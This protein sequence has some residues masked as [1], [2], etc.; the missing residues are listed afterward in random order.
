MTIDMWHNMLSLENWIK[1]KYC[2]WTSH[3][4]ESELLKATRQPV[5]CV[6]YRLLLKMYLDKNQR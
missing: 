5:F 1:I 2:V 6:Y 3:E 4:K